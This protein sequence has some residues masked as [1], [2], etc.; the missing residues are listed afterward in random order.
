VFAAE[1]CE[2]AVNEISDAANEQL[3]ERLSQVPCY[4]I[5]EAMDGDLR[6]AVTDDGTHGFSYGAEW[7]FPKPT[8]EKQPDNRS[9]NSFSF[10]FDPTPPMPTRD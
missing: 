7:W 1:Q 8:F 5:Y 9:V 6:D 10:S 4:V 3:S 2:A